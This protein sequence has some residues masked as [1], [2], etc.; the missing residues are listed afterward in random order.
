MKTT[1]KLIPIICILV[2]TILSIG[3]LDLKDSKKYL[4]FKGYH[5][6]YISLNYNNNSSIDKQ[7]VSK[8]LEIADSNHV[9]ILK[10][11][12]SVQSEKSKNVYLSFSNISQLYYFMTKNF[13]VKEK[14]MI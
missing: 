6:E 2:T 10:N 12:S 1:T 9:L 11:N 8:M 3:F 13:H 14:N 4:N 7:L 5:R